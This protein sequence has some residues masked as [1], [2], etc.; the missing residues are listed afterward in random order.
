MHIARRV[1]EMN[2]AETMTQPLGE[3]LG[4]L[5]DRQPGGI[6]GENSLLAQVWRN[7]RI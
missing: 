7:L 4:Q 5:I 2:A 1:E 3:S 6:T